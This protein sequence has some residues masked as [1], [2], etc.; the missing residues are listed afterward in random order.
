MRR[1]LPAPTLADRGLVLLVVVLSASLTVAATLTSL[2]LR[3]SADSMSRDAFTSAPHPATQLQVT[4]ASTPA[5][6]IPGGGSAEVDAAISPDLR[7]VFEAPRHGVVTTEMVPKILPQQPAQPAYLSVAGIPDAGQHVEIVSGQLPRTGDPVTTLPSAVAAEYDGDPRTAVVEVALEVSASRELEMPAGTWVALSSPSYQGLQRV[8]TAVLHVVGTF[9]AAD[10][11]PSPLDDID[12]LRKPSISILPELNLVRATALAADEETVLQAT[13]E[14]LPD[15]RWSFDLARAPSAAQSEPLVEEARRAELQTWPPVVDSPSVTA[16]TGVGRIAETVVAQRTTSDGLLALV[17]TALAA[18]GLAVLLAAAVVL[19]G[20]RADVTEVVRARGAGARWLVA[21]RGG[22]ALLLTAPGVV[23]GLGAAWLVSS[24]DLALRELVVAVGLAA[25]CAALV[26][27]A[28][29]YRT[30]GGTQLRLVLRDAAQ[31]GVVLLAG[32]AT[33][34]VLLDQE[35]APDDPVMLVTAPLLGVAAGVAL[36]RLLQVLLGGL[37]VLTR[38][39]RAAT[40][41]VSLS[42]S[43][44]VARQVMLPSVALVLAASAGVLAVAVG[45][46]LRAGADQTGWEVAGADVAVVA[47]GLDDGVVE[48]LRQLPGVDLVAPVF[49]AE[50]V[51]LDTRGG[52]EGVTVVGVDPATLATVG[53]ERLRDLSL[54]PTVD[55]E[56]AAVASPDL[57]LADERASLRYALDSV[58][59]RVVDRIDRIPGVTEGESFVLVDLT[60]LQDAVGRPLESYPRILV[61]GDPDPAAVEGVVQE[62]DPQAIVLTRDAVASDRLE[63]PAVSRTLT[64]TG[65]GVAVAA[66]LALFAVLLTVGLGAPVRRRTGTVLGVLG[67]D[68]RQARWVGALGLLP[69]VA[70]TCVAAAG[71]GV[72]LTLVAGRGFDIAALTDTLGDLPVRPTAISTVGILAVLTLLVLLAALAALPR[73]SRA[74]TLDRLDTEHR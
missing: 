12:A 69:V 36:M 3:T 45:D 44:A 26:T 61:Q 24:G 64:M 65:T 38:R 49:S 53:E 52:V 15:I 62:A 14:D 63:A 10:P 19:G 56:V 54:P 42:Q 11:Y 4:Y 25:T 71:C 30:P 16:A 29:T 72:V 40:G 17:V 8:P 18:G 41:V 43:V 21:Q 57:V 35:L 73:R 34:L 28:Q 7:D 32:G 31:L 59:L 1:L 39:T 70:G 48:Q 6:T 66:A 74:A 68:A 23:I 55:G 13:W 37:R 5:R 67:A 50:S 60:D 47:D 22:E 2:W 27:A 51:S 58:E 46:S 20:R 33:V 9:R